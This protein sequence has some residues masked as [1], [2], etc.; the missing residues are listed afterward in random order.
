MSIFAGKNLARRH[1]DSAY[2]ENSAQ[3]QQ[4]KSQLG[5][6][7]PYVQKDIQQSFRYILDISGI[8]VA[9]ISEVSRPSYTVESEEFT[10]LNHKVYY[11]K[12]HVKWEPITFNVREIFSRDVMNSMLGTLMKK[13]TN[14]AYDPPNNISPFSDLKDLSKYDLK[15][16][17]G[18]VKIKMLN[19]DGDLYEEW[20]LREPFIES[21]TPSG[22]TYANDSLLG[23][24]VKIRYDWAELTYNKL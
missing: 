17:L 13:L 22:L 1:T 10:L 15:R 14:T 5:P 4:T 11:P 9:L 6:T 12:G 23:I 19:P 20:L 24:K 8:S 3:E 16:S 21:V 18:S 7:S 2:K